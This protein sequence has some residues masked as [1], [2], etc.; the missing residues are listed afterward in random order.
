[1]KYIP[2]L[3]Y[4]NTEA[5]RYFLHHHRVEKTA[6]SIATQAKTFTSPYYQA[7]W[8]NSY[9]AQNPKFQ[10]IMLPWGPEHPERQLETT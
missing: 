10:G 2:E 7:H 1:M 5:C 8:C 4:A 3:N 9:K 6:F